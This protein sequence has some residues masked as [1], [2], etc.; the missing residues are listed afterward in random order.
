MLFLEGEK[1]RV[2]KYL[3]MLLFFVTL[4]VTNFFK[5]EE[6]SASS[7]LRYNESY[8]TIIGVRGN[9]SLVEIQSD[10][11]TQVSLETLKK[12]ILEYNNTAPIFFDENGYDFTYYVSDSFDCKTLL[13]SSS[14]C[15]I[16]ISNTEELNRD[17]FFLYYSLLDVEVNYQNYNMLNDFDA[18]LIPNQIYDSLVSYLNSN[19]GITLIVQ[20]NQLDRT[21]DLTSLNI[22]LISV[23]LINILIIIE[24]VLRYK[25]SIAMKLLHGSSKIRVLLQLC[26]KTVVDSIVAFVILLLLGKFITNIIYSKFVAEYVF[27]QI[28][29]QLLLALFTALLISVLFL[30]Y[31]VTTSR[32]KLKDQNSSVDKLSNTYILIYFTFSVLLLNS[33]IIS[34]FNNAQTIYNGNV[35]LNNVLEYSNVKIDTID[36]SQENI[37]YINEYI[38]ESYD[39]LILE[40]QL[41]DTT[42]LSEEELDNFGYFAI[43]VM[44]Y[45]KYNLLYG[46]DLKSSD[47]CLSISSR[48]TEEY[49]YTVLGDNQIT[50]YQKCD[51]V[52]EDMTVL[53]YDFSNFDVSKSNLGILIIDSKVEYYDS[54]GSVSIT[55]VDT[56]TFRENI[57]I[58]NNV[59]Y[60]VFKSSLILLF[61]IMVMCEILL[62]KIYFVQH[63][64]FEYS[65]FIFSQK[66]IAGTKLFIITYSIML[67]VGAIGILIKEVKYGVLLFLLALLL[68]K[69][70]SL[71]WYNYKFSKRPKSLEEFYD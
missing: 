49:V 14:T 30:I 43:K 24:S 61:C 52:N 16:P 65:R 68:A 44:D 34:D 29:Q 31:I 27:N 12:L 38:D 18:I 1:L 20:T 36:Y 6:M 42:L 70:I 4:I 33:A 7:D 60:N 25:R 5:L 48:V 66:K 69:L 21:I 22:V 13:E 45:R 64:N 17:S 53:V 57:I 46:T 15:S 62:C 40:L 23:I 56:K 71:A 54:N 35:K 28:I 59:M 19:Y 11:C 51:L 26:L 9:C 67:F 41:L 47:H 55:V 39:D 2:L 58:L 37:N 63:K 32:T 50:D 3:F 10:N 8:S